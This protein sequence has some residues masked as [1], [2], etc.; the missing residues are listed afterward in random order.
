MNIYG[1][2]Y[3]D[4]NIPLLVENVVGKNVTFVFIC[5]NCLNCAATGVCRNAKRKWGGG[6]GK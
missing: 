4:K 2:F 5:C 3:A 1:A 6:G